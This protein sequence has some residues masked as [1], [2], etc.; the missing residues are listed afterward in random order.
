MKQSVRVCRRCNEMKPCSDMKRDVR[1]KSG[2]SSYC[3]VCHQNAS[4]KWQKA[5]TERMN[6]VRRNR[7]ALKRDDICA[8]RRGRYRYESVRWD[9]LRYLYKASKEWYE[10]L[11]ERQGNSC[12]ICRRSQDG[13]SKQLCVDHDHECCGKTPTCGNCNRGLLCS[14]CNNAIHHLERD[15]QWATAALR[16]LGGDNDK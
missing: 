3:K 7:Y 16:Y 10:E 5:N 4:V 6:A 9:R 11:L 13:F 14:S 12:A 8:A 1:N 15:Q 2:Y